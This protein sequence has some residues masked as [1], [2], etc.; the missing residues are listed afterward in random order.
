MAHQHFTNHK[1][2]FQWLFAGL[3]MGLFLLTACKANPPAEERIRQFV[4]SGPGCVAP[5]WNNLIPGHS[6][7][8]DLEIGNVRHTS[9]HPIGERYSWDVTRGGDRTFVDVYEGVIKTIGF[10]LGKDFTP[11]V[12]WAE[13]AVCRRSPM[14]LQ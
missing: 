4:A 12:I 1:V 8:A 2:L 14:L 9:L 11:G 13:L 3:W 7:V 6:T 5:C 10:R